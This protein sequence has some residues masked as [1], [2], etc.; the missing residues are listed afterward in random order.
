MKAAI[1]VAEA[2]EERRAIAQ[3]LIPSKLFEQIHFCGTSQEVDFLLE[4]SCID[5]IFCDV[6]SQRKETLPFTASLIEIAET[7]NLQLVFC[8]HL[9][10]DELAQLGVIPNGAH[11]LSYESSPATAVALLNHLLSEQPTAAKTSATRSVEKLIDSSSGI[12]NRYYF[13][14]ILGQELSRAKLTGRPF[15]LLLIAPEQNHKSAEDAFGT[16][17][18]PAIAL[19][20]KEQIRAAD[21]L[22]RIEPRRLA[23]LLPE[24]SSA[25][26]KRVIQRIQCQVRNLAGALPIALKFGLASPIHTNHFNNHSL[27]SEAEAAL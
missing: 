27:L 3:F 23:L 17:L 7:H 19:T 20:I 6:Y 16:D 14:A 1:I 15:S 21:L 25:N 10:P 9:N 18:L 8:S 12:Y 2:A 24:T 13:D 22:C 4:N 11:C 5:L 26:A